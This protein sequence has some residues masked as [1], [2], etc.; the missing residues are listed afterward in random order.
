MKQITDT[1][2]LA[3]SHQCQPKEK[4][5]V[6]RNE[7]EI[8]PSFVLRITHC[9]FRTWKRFFIIIILANHSK[10][11]HHPKISIIVM[12]MIITVTR[13]VPISSIWSIKTSW[14]LLFSVCSSSLIIMIMRLMTVMMLWWYIL[15]RRLQWHDNIPGDDY[16]DDQY[17]TDYVDEN[18]DYAEYK[19]YNDDILSKFYLFG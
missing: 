13:S 4:F 12:I 9:S 8:S 5:L 10:G 7:T 15:W 3:F 11:H 2:D 18:E 19:N 17:Y 14:G 1:F 6:L 16:A